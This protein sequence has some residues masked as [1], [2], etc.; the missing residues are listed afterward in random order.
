MM[1]LPVIPTI[2]VVAA[3]AAM[4]WLGIWQIHRAAWKKDLI[5]RYEANAHLPPVSWPAVP[6]TDDR[7]LYR[8]AAGFCLQ[9]VAWR[10]IAGR[11]LKDEP[12]WSHIAS[13]RVGAEGPDMEVDAGW[14]ILP[15]SPQ[16]RGGPV[17]GLIVPDRLHHIR[18]V[19]D[20]AAPGL[21]P[22]APSSPQDMPNNH[23]A[24][25]LQWFCFAAMALIIYLLALRRRQRAKVADQR[26]TP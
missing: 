2:V 7:L 1:R 5:A 10:D 13:C 18:L 11:N 3:A 21:V 6:P 15:N 16:W 4:V 12:G 22:S 25:A 17:T 8:R 20:K 24:Y 19:A 23:I 9:P 26:P 14:S